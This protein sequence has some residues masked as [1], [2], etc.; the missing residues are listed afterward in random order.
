MTRSAP[1]HHLGKIER[2]FGD[3]HAFAAKFHGGLW[4]NDD[5][6]QPLDL[7]EAPM[8]EHHAD[9]ASVDLAAHLGE[10][11][12]FR[13]PVCVGRLLRHILYFH[14]HFPALLAH[15]VLGKTCTLKQHSSPKFDSAPHYYGMSFPKWNDFATGG[16]AT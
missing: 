9:V 10:M 7:T 6:I 11:A 4:R 2:L 8:S 15:V 12:V 3:G 1:V 14:S 5:G 13:Q 16:R